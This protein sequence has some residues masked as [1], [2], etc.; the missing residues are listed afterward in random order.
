MIGRLEPQEAPALDVPER[1][2]AG[3]EGLRAELLVGSDMTVVATEPAIAQARAYV[4]VASDEPAIELVVAEDGRRLAKRPR[5]PDTD[6]RGTPV[7]S[8]RTPRR[9]SRE[10]TYSSRPYTP[11]AT[12][13]AAAM[14]RPITPSTRPAVATP[15]PALRS[16]TPAFGCARGE[17]ARARRAR[18]PA[19]RESRSPH[20]A[21][22]TLS[23][24][25]VR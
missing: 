10:P 12:R 17:P 15:P 25:R 6:R 19:A 7:R 18:A 21:G 3:V 11:S 9:Y 23:L 20:G 2:P 22:R 4:G 16:A 24:K 5:A 1:T 8:D 14:H 13:A